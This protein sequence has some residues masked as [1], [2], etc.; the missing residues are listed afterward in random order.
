VY[1][2][3]YIYIYIYAYT[4]AYI[5]ED[6]Y[7]HTCMQAIDASIKRMVSEA[8]EIVTETGASNTFAFMQAIHASV[9][10]CHSIFLNHTC[11]T[12]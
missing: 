3:I 9:K 8:L 11:M 2:Y 10:R 12:D 4:Y 1:I 5:S 6:T 7:M